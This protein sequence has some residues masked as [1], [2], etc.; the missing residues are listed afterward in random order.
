ME[1]KYIEFTYFTLFSL[2]LLI[3]AV[4]LQAFFGK[5]LIQAPVHR[6]CP[7]LHCEEDEHC[8]HRKFRC[9]NPPCPTMLYCSKS[10]TESLKGPS[11][12]DAVYCTN[13][14]TCMMKVRRCRWDERCEQQIVRCVSLKEYHEGPPSC[15]GFKCP[16]GTHCVLRE[17]FCAEPPCKL[18]RSCI[19][20]KEMQI[21]FGKCRTL[22]CQ[23]EYECFLRRPENNCSNPPCKHT[24]DC[25]IE[26]ENEENKH[27]R[28]WMCPQMQTCI[29]EIIKPC[30][31]DGC[32]IKRS[33]KVSV[34]DS[35]FSR[36]SLEHK[37][38]VSQVD[39]EQFQNWLRSIK[40]TIGDAY[41]DWLE[42][43]LLSRGEEFRKWLRALKLDIEGHPIFSAREQPVTLAENPFRDTLNGSTLDDLN[44]EI[45]EIESLLKQRNITSILEKILIP[46][47]ILTPPYT[48]LEIAHPKNQKESNLSLILK[49]LLKY[50]SYGENQFLSSP[51]PKIE[52]THDQQYLVVPV[53]SVKDLTRSQ[54]IDYDP[55][56][57]NHKVI[58]DN[59]KIYEERNNNFSFN[60]PEKQ[61]NL[62]LTKDELP[63]LWTE[64][65]D[66]EKLPKKE[67]HSKED[68]IVP[69]EE[70]KLTSKTQYFDDVPVD[71]FEKFLKSV[72]FAP[73]ENTPQTFDEKAIK[74][75]H[76]DNSHEIPQNEKEDKNFELTLVTRDNEDVSRDKESQFSSLN[77]D[78]RTNFTDNLEPRDNISPEKLD[79]IE[80]SNQSN[81]M[82]DGNL[83]L[84]LQQMDNENDEEMDLNL[85]LEPN[86]E[87]FLPYLE[88]L[89]KIV[90]EEIAAENK[91]IELNPDESSI[92]SSILNNVANESSDKS[93]SLKVESYNNSTEK[94]L[95]NDSNSYD[96]EFLEKEKFNKIFTKNQI[97]S[98]T[99]TK[100]SQKPQQEKES[101]TS[102]LIYANEEPTIRSFHNLASYGSSNGDVALPD[103]TYIEY[104]SMKY[105]DNKKNN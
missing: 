33:C 17:S 1:P 58:S 78:G 93:K 95:N 68:S 62:S 13:G 32:K 30:G 10:R 100:L 85:F 46:N 14:Y 49:Y 29:A 71:L 47:K 9:K 4:H 61:N 73:I 103:Y 25:I 8:V 97:I 94:I 86:N 19:K 11:S 83:G 41:N 59:E 21:W 50:S 31:T 15:A 91:D 43:I 7:Y 44:R 45:K 5:E 72:E 102:E 88:T 99:T 35:S 12:C 16:Q 18:L 82:N 80:L 6:G 20:N 3:M 28:G 22:G 75:N 34:N 74:E 92:T 38:D 56:V 53:K 79:N 90:N 104:D 101:R 55:N 42:T 48:P 54:I 69:T 40:N 2:L 81:K 63:S 36:R 26:K 64:F 27:C 105:K 84:S 98:T 57:Q 76:E 96:A 89:M 23:S 60:V 52:N 51:T 39:I 65:Q 67:M 37:N 87:S 77:D 24:P 70:E 66:V